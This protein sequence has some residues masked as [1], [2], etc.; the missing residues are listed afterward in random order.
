ML[1]TQGWVKEIQLQ[2]LDASNQR[3]PVLVNSK[4]GIFEDSESYYWVFFVTQERSRFEGEL[5]K[6]RN[7][8]QASSQ[9]LAQ[10]ERFIKT[11]TDGLPGMMAYWDKDL[12]CRFANRPYKNLFSKETLHNSP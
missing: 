10:S 9:A 11:V 3:I 4:K 1:L 7:L 12:I 8:A 5:L 2:I 6:A